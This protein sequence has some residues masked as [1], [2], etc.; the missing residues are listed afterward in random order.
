M[1]QAQPKTQQTQTEEPTTQTQAQ[2][3]GQ[4]ATAS[5]GKVNSNT[6]CPKFISFFINDR[7]GHSEQLTTAIKN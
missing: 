2:A 3:K 6:K 4:A 7:S 5:N 1:T